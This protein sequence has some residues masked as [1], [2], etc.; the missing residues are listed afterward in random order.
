MVIFTKKWNMR[1]LSIQDRKLN[2][3]EQLIVLNDIDTFKKIE[4]LINKS[5]TL[6]LTKKDIQHRASLANKDIENG[7]V[8]TQEEVEKL[9]QEW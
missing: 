7:D 6:K 4:D 3:I 8:Y 5:H 1:Q 2:V 9:S